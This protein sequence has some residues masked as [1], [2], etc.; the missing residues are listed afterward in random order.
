MPVKTPRTPKYRHHKPSGLAVV[1]LSGRD[2]YLGPYDT[3]GSR[4]KYDRVVADWLANGRRLDVRRTTPETQTAFAMCELMVAYLE[5]AKSYYVKNGRQTGEATNIQDALR[6]VMKLY[7]KLP[8]AEFGPR[9]LKTVREAMVMGGLARKCVNGRV[10]RIRRMFRWGVAEELLAPAVLQA[11]QAVAPLKKGRSAARETA[12]VRPVPDEHIDAVLATVTSTIRAMIEVQR[13]TG[14]RPGELVMMRERDIDKGGTIWTYQ[15]ASH[16]TEHHEIDRQIFLGPKAQMILQPFMWRDAQ[17]YLFN[18][19]ET[20]LERR[21][22]QRMR[23]K[24]PGVR[25]RRRFS[26]RSLRRCQERY[27]TDTYYRAIARACERADIPVWG[28]NR[29]RHNAATLL[30]KQFGI[31]AA[32]V[33]LGHTSSAMTEVY[34]ELDRAKAADIMERVG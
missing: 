18:P 11:L 8:V 19:H 3:P 24:K 33:I 32:R 28:P 34:A 7:T 17:S 5:H 10:N 13:L 27:T 2:I 26:L 1:R 4:S 9:A 20:I 21:K 23:S 12:P 15:P 29:L 22:E 6:P 16:K 14:M 25:E 30:R 31:E